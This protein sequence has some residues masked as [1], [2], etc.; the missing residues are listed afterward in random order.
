MDREDYE[1]IIQELLALLDEGVYIVDDQGIGIFYNQAMAQIEQIHVNDVVGKEYHKAFPGV[2][3]SDS[4]MYFAL[5]KGVKTLN[6]QQSYLNLYGRRV[7]T[8]NSTVPVVRDGKVRAAIEVAKDITT[9]RSMSDTILELRE[10]HRKPNKVAKR[11]RH[12]TFADLVGQAPPFA[13]VI[14]KAKRAAW[15]DAP[16]LI[17]GETGTGKELLAQSLHYSGKRRDKAFLAQ[18]CAALPASLLEGILF[19]TVKGG[20]TGSVDRAGLFEQANGGTLL[21]DEISAMPTDL[22]SKLLRVLQEMYIRRIGG[23]KDIPID[24]RIVATVNEAPAKLIREGKLRRDLYYR[25]NVINIT[26]PPLRER[27]SDI[28]KLAEHLLAKNCEKYD[29]KI[30]CLSDKALEKLA[31][32]DYPGNVRELDNIIAQAVSLADPDEKVLT[33]KALIM[34]MRQGLMGTDIKRF[35]KRGPLPEYLDN[36]EKEIIRETILDSGGNISRTADKLKIKRQTLQHK[37]KKYDLY[38]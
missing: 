31:D 19:G 35:D 33:D 22:Q 14:E 8:V 21:L 38:D 24:T 6:K 27:L 20:F 7:T 36:L 30:E 13:S 23:T 16:V 26:I 17:G 1:K 5:K 3:V 18:N 34:P 15:S 2:K 4:T 29:R 9:I 37:M 28:P 11:I 32:Y 10:R 25:L 12:Y